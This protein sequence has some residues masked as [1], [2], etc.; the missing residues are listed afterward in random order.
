MR[1]EG[2]RGGFPGQE[3]EPDVGD[4]EQREENVSF[5]RNLGLRTHKKLGDEAKPA[6]ERCRQANADCQYPLRSN[7][8]FLERN[9]RTITTDFIVASPPTTETGPVPGPTDLQVRP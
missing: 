8:T 4:V 7:F 5:Y 9:S 2:K 1:T 3:S 6:C